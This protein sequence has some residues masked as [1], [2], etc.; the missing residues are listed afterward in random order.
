MGALAGL[1]GVADAQAAAAVGQAAPAWE[2]LDTEGRSVSAQAFARQITVL[3]WVNPGCPY[4]RRH[5]GAGNMQ[6]TQRDA[7]AQGVAW[8]AV[9]S[10]AEDAAD[11]ISGP[12]MARWMREQSAAATATVMDTDGRIGRMFGARTTPHLYIID[13]SGRLVYAGAIDDQPRARGE[14]IAKARNHVRAAL[15]DLAAGRPVAVPAT[16][17]YGCTVKYAAG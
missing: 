7:S 13:R 6:A 16:Q 5:Y 12:Q 17:P 3:E 14:D 9:N 1:L 2:G 11:A 4:V 15:A 10:T 8:I